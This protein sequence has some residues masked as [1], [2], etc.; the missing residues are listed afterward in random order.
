MREELQERELEELKFGSLEEHEL[1]KVKNKME[2]AIVFSE[3]SN[4]N[5]AYHLSYF[6]LMGNVEEINL[7]IHR[8][9]AIK[10]ED[11]QRVAQQTF[12]RENCSTIYYHAQ[13]N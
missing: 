12:R 13:K 1:N 2:S 9:N 11:I 5:K 3:A 4:S 6:E 10:G 8:Y 7:E